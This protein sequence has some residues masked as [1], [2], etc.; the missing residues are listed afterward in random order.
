MD[1]TPAHERGRRLAF[2]LPAA[3]STQVHGDGRSNATA[4]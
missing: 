1:R 4:S 2:L 3:R